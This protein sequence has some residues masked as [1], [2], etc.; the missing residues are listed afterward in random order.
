[1]SQPQHLGM[2]LRKLITRQERREPKFELDSMMMFLMLID[3]IVGIVY[4]EL[5]HIVIAG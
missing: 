1:M 3:L 2:T 4:I 5:K